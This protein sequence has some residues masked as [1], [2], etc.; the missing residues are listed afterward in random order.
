MYV[1]LHTPI[2]LQTAKA[3]VCN[4]RQMGLNPTLE[5]RA[6]LDLGSQRSYVTAR[7]LEALDLMT[8]WSER[9]VIKTFGSSVGMQQTCDIVDLRIMTKE[10]SPLTISTVVVPHICDPVLTQ[11]ITLLKNAYE[12]LTG[13][14][15]ANSGNDNGESAIDVLVGF[16]HYWKL[17]TGRVIRGSGR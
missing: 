9:M 3:T 1:S 12:H 16:D 8:V 13:L 15:L 11:H 7:V 4:N 10:G 2:L 6:I 5:V 17:V 14:D